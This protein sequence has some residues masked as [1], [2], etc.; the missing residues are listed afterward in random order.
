MTRKTVAYTKIQERIE[1]FLTKDMEQQ[2][3]R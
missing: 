1:L 3:S 2:S